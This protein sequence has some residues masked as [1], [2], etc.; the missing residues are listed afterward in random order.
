MSKLD[1]P[2]AKQSLP[3]NSIRVFV[4]AARQLS[5]SRAALVLGMTQGGVSRHVARLENHLGHRLFARAGGSAG[6][7]D[8]GRLYFDNLRDAMATIELTTRQLSNR[9]ARVQRLVVRT[10]L[11]TLAVLV[12]IPAL[13]SFV[14]QPQVQVDVVTS[15]SPPDP[16]DFYDVLVSRDLVLADAEHWLLSTENLVCVATPA[17]CQAFSGRPISNWPFISATS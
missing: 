10:S 11:P 4:E 6:L 7:T 13:A 9:P 14:T 1:D 16:A 15:L 5:F 12:L 8:V 2:S 3:L 17:V